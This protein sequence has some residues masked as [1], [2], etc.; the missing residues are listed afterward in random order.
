MDV[1]RL[2]WRVVTYPGYPSFY[3]KSHAYDVQALWYHT[4]YLQVRRRVILQ[5]LL[6]EWHAKTVRHHAHGKAGWNTTAASSVSY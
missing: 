5:K 4:R 6:V 2:G 3:L 1:P